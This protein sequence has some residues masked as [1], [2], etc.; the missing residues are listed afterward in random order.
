M[1]FPRSIAFELQTAARRSP[2]VTLVGP[3]QSGKTTLARKTFPD[4]P[5]LSLENPDTRAYAV[6]DP[7]G[8]LAD[9]ESGAILDEFQRVPD[10]IS[11]LQG[12]VDENPEPGRFILTGSQHFL[13]M[14]TVSQSLAGRTEILTLLPLSLR[15]LS[16]SIDVTDPDALLYKGFYPRIHEHGTDPYPVLRDYL[17]TYVERDVR[18]LLNVHDLLSFETFLRLCAGRVGQ[19]LNLNSLANDAGISPTTAKQ[20]ISILETSFILYRLPP[21]HANVNKRLIKTPKLYFNDVGLAVH[22]CGIEERSQLSSHPLRGAFFENLVVSECCKKRLNSG[23]E[24]RLSFFRDR[25]GNEIDL[26]YP[27]GPQWLPMEIK[28]GKTINSNWV[29]GFK[30]FEKLQPIPDAGPLV[31]YGGAQTQRRG[32]AVICG[33]SDLHA[34]LD[35]KLNPSP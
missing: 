10:L 3:R 6:E 12:M 9:I 13:M 24:S 34:Q 19:L 35:E 21:W 28:S 18:R 23:K 17:Q 16:G 29:K 14:E 7:R 15:E 32:K 26:L 1:Y 30:T 11:Y 4:K 27:K 33:L 2:I 5:Y 31:V 22:L 20:W 8:F 25:T